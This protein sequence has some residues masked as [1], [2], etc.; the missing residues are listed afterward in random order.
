MI[1]SHV[2]RRATLGVGL[3]CAVAVAAPAASSPARALARPG[4][5]V[6]VRP[7]LDN[8]GEPTAS[9][10]AQALPG[11][12]AEAMAASGQGGTT[13]S[14]RSDYVILGPNTGGVGPAGSSPDQM[15]GEVTRG[16]VTQPLRATNY[17]YPMAQDNVMIAQSNHDRVVRL[18][19]AFAGWVARGY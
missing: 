13:V 12:I 2:I 11:A 17:Y 9:W 10:V 8:S 3:A 5:S 1:L 19:Q 6:D 4:V 15:I 18:A 16:G 14:V 7:L